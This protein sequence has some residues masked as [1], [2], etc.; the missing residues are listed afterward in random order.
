MNVGDTDIEFTNMLVE[1]YCNSSIIKWD[2]QENYHAGNESI[3]DWRCRE[4]VHSQKKSLIYK[5]MQT[6]N[7]YCFEEL[8]SKEN[9]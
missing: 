5:I 7:Q 4:G 8:V 9:I 6:I 3:P 1:M 2:L